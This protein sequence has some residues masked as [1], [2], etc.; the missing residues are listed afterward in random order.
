L[1]QK[2]LRRQSI[3]IILRLTGITI[4]ALF[5]LN[6]GVS[7]QNSIDPL[8]IIIHHS[9]TGYRTTLEAI[10]AAHKSRGFGVYY[11]GKTYYI[12]YHYVIFPDGT[13]V[14]TRPE[15]L[16][17]AHARGYNS[18]IGICLIGNFS[19]KTNQYGLR[20]RRRPTLY[21]L[22]SLY[23]LCNQLRR[24]YGF[25]LSEI[26]RHSDVNNQT[27]CPGDR[28]PYRELIAELSNPSDHGALT[29]PG[30]AITESLGSR[31]DNFE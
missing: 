5:M 15:H 4:F 2:I 13:V 28:F 20:R 31:A 14:A 22:Q 16:R 7:W 1:D 18:Y 11:W 19:S 27:E 23:E 10:E 21:Q 8:G 9:A 29:R 12:G 17:G 30:A 26:R 6:A 25:G 24:R 3:H